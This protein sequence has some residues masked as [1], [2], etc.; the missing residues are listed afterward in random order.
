MLE[1]PK[2]DLEAM[3]EAVRAAYALDVRALT[4]L[5]IGNDMRSFVYR[6]A[7]ANGDL[8][9]KAR[10][11][12]PYAPA[13]QVP[14][15]LIDS[16]IAEIV[17]PLPTT[18]GDLGQPFEGFTLL[19]YPFVSG[20][21]AMNRGLTDA[22]WRAHG[23]ILHRVHATCLSDEVAAM[24]PIDAYTPP[25]MPDLLTFHARVQREKFAGGLRA[26]ASAFWREHAA[27][28]GLMIERAAMFGDAL[29]A[30][31]LPHVLCHADIHTANV[32]VDDAGG[33]HYVDWD[34][35]MF[36]PRER[37]LKFMLGTSI[38]DPVTLMQEDVFFAGY[39]IG[40]DEIDATAL[41]YYRHEWVIE[42]LASY[43]FQTFFEDGAGE[44]SVAAAFGGLSQIFKPGDTVELALR[45]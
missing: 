29:R 26:E 11:G 20:D 22:Q 35:P 34:G 17:A 42:D 9:L 38:G 39:G 19:L 1:P 14:R 6:L 12:E 15:A 18:R 21:S 30:R 13:L 45:S 25:S 7:T 8:F 3:A 23:A 28:I 16:G 5:P 43:C 31:G 41:A 32:M 10:A 44:I 4:F 40:R 27:T 2:I 33:V 36:A 37:D 24:L